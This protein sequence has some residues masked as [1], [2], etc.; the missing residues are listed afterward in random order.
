MQRVCYK[1]YRCSSPHRNG[2]E[3]PR[4]EVRNNKGLL[5]LSVGIVGAW[6]FAVLAVFLAETTHFTITKELLIDSILIANMISA[7]I[8]LFAFSRYVVLKDRLLQFIAFAFLVGGFIRVV[9][10]VVADLGILNSTAMTFSFQITAW[11]GGGILFGL[12]LCV[13]TLL[14]WIYPG[15]KSSLLDIL[16]EVVIIAVLVSVTFVTLHGLGINGSFI[17]SSKSYPLAFIISGLYLV[18][19][20]GVSRNYLKFPTLFNYSISIALFLLMISELVGSFSTSFT[21]TA[22]AVQAGMSLIAF[23]VGAVGSLVDVGQIFADYVRNS[24]GL[25]SANQELLRNEIEI[26]NQNQRLSLINKT[27]LAMK[28]VLDV[29]EIVKKSLASLLESGSLTAAAIYLMDEGVNELN[30]AASLGFSTKFDETEEVRHFSTRNGFMAHVVGDGETKMI[31]RTSWDDLP[32]EVCDALVSEHVAS[33]TLTPII[34]TRKLYGVLLAASGTETNFNEKDS[35]FFMMISRVIGAAIENAV[36]YS[37]VL[38]KSKELEDSNEQLRMSKVWIEEANAQLVEANQQLEDASR[39]KSQFLA[40]MSHEL[41]TPLNSIIGF[42]NLIL[43]DD[44]QPPNGEQKEGLEI[45][46]RNAKNLLA[47][48]NDILDLSKIEAGRLTITP[49]EFNI[50][51]LVSDALMTVE[52]LLGEKPVKLLSEL[53][54]Q[55]PAM[56]S[57]SARIKQIVLNLLSNAAK[58]TDKGHIKVIGKRVEDNFLSL[59]VE[60][61]GTGIPAEY[62]DVVFEE[63]RQVDGSNTRKHGGTGLGLAISRRLARMLGGDLTLKS[64]IGKGSTFTITVPLVFRYEK[65]KVEEK[66]AAPPPPTQ[67]SQMNNLVVCIDDDPEVLILLKNHL[68]SE[69]FE[70]FGVSDSRAAIDTVRKNKPVLITLD[71]VSGGVNC[72]A[73]FLQKTSEEV[74]EIFVVIDDEYFAAGRSGETPYYRNNF[75][76]IYRLDEV[77]VRTQ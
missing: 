6:V 42:T 38:E 24:E 30:L 54:P 75:L 77:G 40:N 55:I 25:K 26:N 69:G 50:D 37:D 11:R 36:L 12:M 7:A 5:S 31:S 13:G 64:E 52:P 39:L 72:E 10:V 27:A 28:D 49:E 46:L 45:V 9:G 16:V 66:P 58:F 35:E 1:T 8:S 17:S 3:I 14:V 61:T 34:G 73:A 68:E 15:I 33:A 22:L 19:F 60:D 43:T 32:G 2:K 56:N 59:A 65:D 53:D 29:N 62:L 23:T 47:L 74:C 48:I 4:K 71:S 76:G 51:S 20:I 18:S 41:R 63:F 70:F 21:D 44:L 67:S 57:D